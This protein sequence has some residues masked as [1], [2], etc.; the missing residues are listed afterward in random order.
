[1]TA[2]SLRLDT[3]LLVKP[4]I[5]RAGE[6]FRHLVQLTEHP[7]AICAPHAL[8]DTGIPDKQLRGPLVAENWAKSVNILR[9]T[10]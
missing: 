3:Y 6:T 2:P 9:L 1:M 10:P 5:L 8:C 4:A 7:C